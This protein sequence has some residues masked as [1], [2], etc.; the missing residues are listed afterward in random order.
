MRAN[1]KINHFREK[2]LRQKTHAPGSIWRSVSMITGLL[3]HRFWAGEN[4]FVE[5][6]VSVQG[7]FLW[8]I[9]LESK[10]GQFVGGSLPFF[11]GKR[12][13]GEGKERGTGGGMVV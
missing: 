1:L 7:R 3:R 5:A 10:G 2:R 11:G 12:G 4:L 9:A 6:R 13:S 8:C